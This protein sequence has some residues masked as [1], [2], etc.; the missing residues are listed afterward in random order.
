MSGLKKST[1]SSVPYLAFSRVTIVSRSPACVT[2]SALPSMTT[3]S[4]GSSV[5]MV[6]RGSPRR[7]RALRERLLLLNH[8]AASCQIPHT[9]MTCGRPS[10]H[11]VTTQ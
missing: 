8:S 11:S 6:H 7:L 10:A 4:P 5:A 1:V 3:G 9:G 2:S